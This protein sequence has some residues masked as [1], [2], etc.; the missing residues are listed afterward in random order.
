MA[1]LLILAENDE[2]L[3]RWKN[4]LSISSTL[5]I[6]AKKYEEFDVTR[7]QDEDDTKLVFVASYSLLKADILELSSHFNA[8][9]IPIVCTENEI[10]RTISNEELLQKGIYGTINIHL[11]V[12]TIRDVL[13][14]VL[15]GG[16]FIERK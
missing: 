13:D 14:M 3:A 15:R 11:S 5:T 7:L 10:T 12:L 16:V 8:L 1:S 4:I 9:N 6:R 2:L